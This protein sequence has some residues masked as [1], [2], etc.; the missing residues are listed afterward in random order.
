MAPL[1]QRLHSKLLTVRQSGSTR[2]AHSNG[3]QHSGRRDIGQHS[4]DGSLGRGG[5]ARK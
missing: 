2:G 5:S 3:H 1:D 4:A